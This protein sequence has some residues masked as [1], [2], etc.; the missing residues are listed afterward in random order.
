MTSLS[1][2]PAPLAPRSAA[3]TLSP[4]TKWVLKMYNLDRFEE[5]SP[6]LGVLLGQSHSTSGQ[7]AVTHRTAE[8]GYALEF[9]GYG[10]NSMITVDHLKAL[11]PDDRRAIAASDEAMKKLVEEWN[12]TVR[13]GRLS[14]RDNERLLNMYRTRFPGHR[15]GAVR[16]SDGP[17]VKA[18]EMAAALV[19][20]DPEPTVT[21]Q[22]RT[23]HAALRCASARACAGV[24]CPSRWISHWV[25]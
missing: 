13:K 9:V 17:I 8:D 18:R 3:K 1:N 12:K 7:H 22:R 23:A 11:P 4:A 2:S 25:L 20:I 5:V 6:A 24:R 10:Q 16:H 14:K 21:V 19:T 15:I